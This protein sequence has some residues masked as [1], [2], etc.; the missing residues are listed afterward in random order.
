MEKACA[1]YS[2]GYN[3]Y[4]VNYFLDFLCPMFLEEIVE[5][6]LSKQSTNY[7]KG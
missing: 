6:M 4:K 5:H 1:E 3:K 2:S 7:T